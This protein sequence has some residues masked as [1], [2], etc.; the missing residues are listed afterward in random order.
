[1]LDVKWYHRRED[2]KVVMSRGRDIPYL[3]KPPS[4]PMLWIGPQNGN[5]SVPANWTSGA[6]PGSW[7]R[8]VYFDSRPEN[9]GLNTPCPPA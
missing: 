9:E 4:L 1:M 6:V 2:G 5:F 8:E 3:F 7:R